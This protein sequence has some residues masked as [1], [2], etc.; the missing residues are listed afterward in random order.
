MGQVAQ[1]KGSQAPHSPLESWE[2]CDP[3]EGITGSL[4][5]GGSRQ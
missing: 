5:L 1:K 2:M 4:W 3:T